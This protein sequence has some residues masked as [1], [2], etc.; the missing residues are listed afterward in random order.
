MNLTKKLIL[1]RLKEN[2]PKEYRR[3]KAAG[4]LEAYLEAEAEARQDVKE[5][6]IRGGMQPWEA[7]EVLNYS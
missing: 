3:L 5:A 4:E 6:M 7:N 2:D 1:E